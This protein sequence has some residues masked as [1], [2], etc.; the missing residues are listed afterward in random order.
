M[1][2]AWIVL[3]LGL[4]GLTACVNVQPQPDQTPKTTVV[5][6]T[7]APAVITPAP[8][9]VAPGTTVITHP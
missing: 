4:L 8:A 1:R 6:P 7:P 2:F 5:T 3:P 9:M